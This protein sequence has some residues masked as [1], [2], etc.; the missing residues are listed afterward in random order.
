MINW[1]AARFGYI[2]NHTMTL[3]EVAE[4]Y[5]AA[6][7]TVWRRSGQEGWKE[8]R[9]AAS[10]KLIE[11]VRERTT[12]SQSEELAHCNEDDLRI[13][14]LFK[15]RVEARVEARLKQATDIP[16]HAMRSLE[17]VA[18]GAQ[19]IARLALGVSTENLHTTHDPYAQMS[20][21]ELA[22]ELQRLGIEPTEPTLQ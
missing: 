8:Q 14:A 11:K 18:E 20:D 19:R 12:L 16:D 6:P 5:H 15:A 22:A 17:A 13:A 3:A 2:S 10:E 9:K 1:E 7:A 21:A 4:K